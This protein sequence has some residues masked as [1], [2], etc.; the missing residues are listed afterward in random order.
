[1]L[2]NKRIVLHTSCP[3][4]S[5][6]LYSTS[7]RFLD[8]VTPNR[9]E[10]SIFHSELRHFIQILFTSATY[11][12]MLYQ[13]LAVALGLLATTATASSE[14]TNHGTKDGWFIPTPEAQGTVDQVTNVVYK[15]TNALKM[16]QTYVPGRTGRYHSEVVYNNGYKRGDHKFYGFAFRLSEK[17]EFDGTQSYNIAQWIAD[18]TDSGCDDWSPTTM[19]FLR[20]NTLYSRVKT[21]QLLPGKPCANPKTD[22]GDGRNCQVIR[23]FKLQDGIQGGVWYKMQFEVSWKSDSTGLFRTWVNG[24]KV[25]DESNIPTTLVD[26][27]R[28][29]SFRLGLYANGWHDDNGMTGN[30]GFRQ[31]WIDEVGVGSTM[32]DADPANL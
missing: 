27:G 15:G 3:L 29:F 12:A 2:L 16:T 22:C 11:T 5:T 1:M 24:N 17:W 10:A 30:Q 28:E 7:L 20:G 8:R 9:L 23:E 21:G 19:V 4:H 13:T 6:P 14:F 18:F 32:A 26:D 31:V 25:H